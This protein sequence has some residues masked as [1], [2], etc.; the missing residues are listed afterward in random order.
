MV[1]QVLRKWIQ[2]ASRFILFSELWFDV[3]LWVGQYYPECTTRTGEMPTSP[4]AMGYAH[5]SSKNGRVSSGLPLTFRH[6]CQEVGEEGERTA[7]ANA[8]PRT[9]LRTSSPSHTNAL[10][11]L[12]SM[13][14]FIL[15]LV[16]GAKKTPSSLPPFT[17][18]LVHIPYLQ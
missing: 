14:L 12:G 15:V 7:L 9:R 3:D 17:Y 16:L 11:T 6:G 1:V 5:R 13:Q 10:T 18:I 8:P 2:S 4:W